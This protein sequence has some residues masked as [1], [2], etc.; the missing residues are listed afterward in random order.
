VGDDFRRDA[1]ALDIELLIEGVRQAR[2]GAEPRMS[3]EQMRES[4][5]WLKQASE[6]ARRPAADDAGD[7]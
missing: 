5:V 6:E 4:L 3:P 7:P 2:A 1:I